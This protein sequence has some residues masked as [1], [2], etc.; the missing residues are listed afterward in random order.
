M[1]FWKWSRARLVLSIITCEG[2][3]ATWRER[4]QVAPGVGSVS[5]ADS[6]QTVPQYYDY[7]GSLHVHST[8]SDGTGTVE[9]IADAANKA[10]LDFIILC[11]HSNLDARRYGQDGWQ[12]RTLVL[13]G[14]E[15]TTD[16][17]HLLALDVPV[18]FLPAP[19]NA[20]K[21]QRAILETGG[22]GFIAL[23][24]DLKDHWRNFDRRIPNIGLEVF[25][26]SAIARA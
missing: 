2:L 7:A 4:L 3:F 11:D 8:Y 22:V 19:S 14:T 20:V 13:A 24:L 25:N 15:I 9:E 12:G 10:E 5:G 6:A 16:T 26:L 17:G 18:S 23:P 1:S 21:A